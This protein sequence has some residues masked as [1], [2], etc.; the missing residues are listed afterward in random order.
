MAPEQTLGNTPTAASD[1][2]VLGILAWELLAGRSLFDGDDIK[3]ILKS[4]RN[5]KIEHIK[6]IRPD[7]PTYLT[8][9]IMRALNR[10]PAQRG[11]AASIGR[12][13]ARAGRAL[14]GASNTQSLSNWLEEI[15]PRKR[16][17]SDTLTDV[18]PVAAFATPPPPSPEAEAAASSESTTATHKLAKRRRTTEKVLVAEGTEDTSQHLDPR[19]GQ[20][21]NTRLRQPALSELIDKR[22]VVVS[23][24]ILDGG[25]EHRRNE[26]SY[27]LCDLAYKR[28]AVVH[29]RDANEVVSI[30]GLQLAGEDDVASAMQ[31]GM[32][33]CDLAKERVDTEEQ[34]DIAIRSAAR[35]GVVAQREGRNYQL[36]GDALREARELAREAEPNRPLLSGGAG[37]VASAQFRFRE[38]PARSYRSRRLRVL[39]LIGP[40]GHDDRARAIRSRRGRF[41][42]RQ[43]ELDALQEAYEDT[44]GQCQ[45][46]AVM[47]CGAAGVGKSRLVAEFV[48]RMDKECHLIA[49]AST[50]HA[51]DAPFA[52]AIDYLQ[53]ALQLA[54]GRGEKARSR[55]VQRLATVLKESEPAKAAELCHAVELAMELRDGA[56]SSKEEAPAGLR[57]RCAE[58]IQA[59]HTAIT[60]NR[61]TSLVLENIHLAD[62]ASIEVLRLLLSQDDCVSPTL[63]LMTSKDDSLSLPGLQRISLGDLDEEDR[64]ELISD[65]L[66][67]ARTD[68]RILEVGRRAGGNAL[69]IEELCRNIRDVGWDA[70]PAT[71]RDTVVARTDRLS[72]KSRAALQRA[73]VIGQ[74]FRARILEELIAAPADDELEELLAEGLLVREGHS[75][76][77]A[78]GGEYRFRHALIQEVMYDSLSAGAR[79]ATHGKLGRLLS[80]RDEAGLNELPV[81]TARHLELGGL[82]DESAAYWCKAGRV[83]Q[84]AFETA[85]ASE[86][87]SRAIEICRKIPESTADINDRLVEALFGRAQCHNSVG[88]YDEEGKDLV[89]LSSLV[90]DSPVARSE[91]LLREA[92]RSLR[93]GNFEQALKDAEEAEELAVKSEASLIEGEALRLRSNAKE[94]LGLFE[95]GLELAG[96]ALS[97]FERLGSR[98]QVTLTQISMAR[99][100]LFQGHY[101]EA[102]GLYQPILADLEKKR[103]PWIERIAHNHLAVLHLCL[104]E[105]DKAMRYAQESVDLCERNGDQARAGDNLTV[106][107]RVFYTLGQ[108]SIANERFRQAIAL[109]EATKSKWNLCDCLIHASRSFA[110]AGEVEQASEAI[111][112]ACSYAEGLKSP[113]LE[114]NSAIAL[115]ECHLAAGE[116]ADLEIAESLAE[117][118]AMNAERSSLLG[119]QTLAL[120]R[121]AQA[122]ARQGEHQR[123]LL[124]STTAIQL[125]DRQR[126]LEGSEQ[127]VLYAHYELLNKEEDPRADSYLERAQKNLDRKLDQIEDHTWRE[128]FCDEVPTNAAI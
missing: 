13:L 90:K 23:V 75:D 33:A 8:D 31:F 45:P 36:R 77:E 28:G 74:S 122:V 43:P 26:L 48:G 39:E 97:L 2:F 110:R 40:A 19:H 6:E 93:H 29:A 70:T 50:A 87:Y 92:A 125:L 35:A 60:G 98:P 119:A 107:A 115:A 38:L 54:P 101:R 103:D 76:S 24:L 66:G 64:A 72:S 99:N 117:E 3:A 55:L 41:V 82:L 20:T 53:A 79:R 86:N 11:S 84:A 49:V 47:I 71:V 16:K 67:D 12:R 1:V 32:D 109:H 22:R 68:E 56:L 88:N 127:E 114:C 62:T 104:G 126:Y 27:A 116:D 121:Q 15:F 120:C 30:F 65:R 106:L 4:V 10:D 5:S 52:V 83:A 9:A 58:S 96:R 80:L 111:R 89:A 95:E 94:R 128:S 63:I 124:L 112:Q 69:Y 102:L 113:Y 108:Y 118:A 123:A 100:H 14:S 17:K 46:T 21:Q 44:T 34:Q 7:L 61:P 85:T 57:A 73:A 105:L 91:F 25:S 18:K 81:V 42:G 51:E 37:R 78:E 59:A